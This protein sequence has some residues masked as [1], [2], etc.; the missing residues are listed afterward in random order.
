MKAKFDDEGNAYY[1]VPSARLTHVKQARDGKP[2]IRVQEFNKDGTLQ[3][4]R[5][6]KIPKDVTPL[7]YLQA[8]GA[9]LPLSRELYSP[10][11]ETQKKAIRSNK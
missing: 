3:R 5:E 6:L 2:R 7:A 1:D 8:I 9:V 4:G 11:H 10:A